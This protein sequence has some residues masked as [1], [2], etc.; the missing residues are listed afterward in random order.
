[1][2]GFQV[3]PFAHAG[4]SAIKNNTDAAYVAIGDSLR[5]A[6]A[7]FRS[8]RLSIE[9]VRGLGARFIPETGSVSRQP[10]ME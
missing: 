5:G 7:C 6:G 3:A 10:A 9:V 2:E 4:A 1:M 8:V